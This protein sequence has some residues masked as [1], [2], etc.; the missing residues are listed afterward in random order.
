MQGFFHGTRHLHTGLLDRSRDRLW[1][2]PLGSLPFLISILILGRIPILILAQE[3]EQLG[4]P[5]P[6]LLSVA[7][8]SPHPSMHAKCTSTEV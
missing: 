1:R 4:T 2:L 6:R 3:Q 7:A 5:Q 8:T